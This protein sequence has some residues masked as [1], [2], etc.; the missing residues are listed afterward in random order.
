MDQKE[1]KK[2]LA[3]LSIGTLVAGATLFGVD[4]RPAQAA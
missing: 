3:G 4:T 1:L 2:I